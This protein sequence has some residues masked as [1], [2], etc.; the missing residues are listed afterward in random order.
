MTV[1]LFKLHPLSK[2]PV[3]KHRHIL[4][5]WGLGRQDMTLGGCNS[6]CDT[7]QSLAT[8]TV[9]YLRRC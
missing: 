2:D 8:V 7:P 1:A 5:C 6:A 9:L 4:R 3:S